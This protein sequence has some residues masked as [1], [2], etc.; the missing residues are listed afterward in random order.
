MNAVHHGYT[1]GWVEPTGARPDYKSS[2]R[3]WRRDVGGMSADGGRSSLCFF[4]DAIITHFLEMNDQP[5]L[6][7]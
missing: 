7:H 4:W 3:E 1:S 6:T 5:L 2:Q